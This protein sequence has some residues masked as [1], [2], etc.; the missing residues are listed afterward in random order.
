LRPPAELSVTICEPWRVERLALEH[1][2]EPTQFAELNELLTR[3]VTRVSSILSAKLVG[4]YLTGS[5]A[6]GAG[7]AASD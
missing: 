4:V 5:F 7:D 3:F 1:R 6:L 2:A